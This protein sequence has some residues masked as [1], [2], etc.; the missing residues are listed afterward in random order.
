MAHHRFTRF[1]YEMMN[2]FAPLDALAVGVNVVDVLVQLPD[3]FTPG[4]KQPARDLVVQGGGPAATAACVLGALGWRTGFVTRLGDN[5]LSTIS[6]AE[7]KRYGIV[8]DF[9]I[10]DPDA[11]SEK[12]DCAAHRDRRRARQ[13]GAHRGWGALPASVRRGRS[14]HN[15][16]R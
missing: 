2:E 7:F 8:D 6:R 5:A 16:L 1:S 3:H 9:F 13:L 15:G 4:E 12:D 14:R 10:T 11:S